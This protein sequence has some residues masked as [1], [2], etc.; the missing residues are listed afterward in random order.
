M[1]KN[2]PT[3]KPDKCPSHDVELLASGKIPQIIPPYKKITINEVAIN[4]LF[5]LKTPEKK[6]NAAK[7]YTSPLAPI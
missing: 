6:W 2:A 3:T 5:W 1:D 7:A 4:S